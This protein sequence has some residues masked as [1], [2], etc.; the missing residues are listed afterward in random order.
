VWQYLRALSHVNEGRLCGEKA[1]WRTG[2]PGVKLGS[3]SW[4]ELTCSTQKCEK[5][6]SEGNAQLCWLVWGWGRHKEQ[7][8]G[9]ESGVVFIL[10]MQLLPYFISC[11]EKCIMCACVSMCEYVLEKNFWLPLAEGFLHDPFFSPLNIRQICISASWGTDCDSPTEKWGKATVRAR[12]LQI[13]GEMRVLLTH[14][15]KNSAQDFWHPEKLY[16]DLKRISWDF[17]VTSV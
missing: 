14:Y 15:L 6:Y 7:E 10:A 5:N 16:N 4:K 3:W 1:L 8:T 17:L 9:I 11:L 13:A 2:R 12:H